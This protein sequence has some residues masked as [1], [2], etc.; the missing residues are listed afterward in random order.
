MMIVDDDDKSKKEILKDSLLFFHISSLLRFPLVYER[1]LM[2]SLNIDVDDFTCTH[3]HKWDSRL[4][5]SQWVS[6]LF[7]PHHHHFFFVVSLALCVFSFR[8]RLGALGYASD[9]K[10]SKK[11]VR[12]HVHCAEWQLPPYGSL[13]L[14]ETY[15]ILIDLGCSYSCIEHH[16]AA[17][18]SSSI[19]FMTHTGTC[20]YVSLSMPTCF[21]KSVL[22]EYSIYLR[23]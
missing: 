21:V 17:S 18:S 1:S 5:L 22:K 11:S 4:P 7:N 13:R 9:F 8:V 15:N 10:N 12:W 23:A 14:S 20:R 16:M 19:Y 6:W 3:S 2:A